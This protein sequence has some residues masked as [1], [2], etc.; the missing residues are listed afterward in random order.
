MLPS[1]LFPGFSVNAGSLAFASRSAVV[2]NG[3]Y[4]AR[5]ANAAYALLDAFPLRIDPQTV[6]FS[7]QDGA[8]PAW[9]SAV[10]DGVSC[11]WICGTNN[12]DQAVAQA[13]SY[14]LASHSAPQGEVPNATWFS[15][16]R[17]TRA[18]LQSPV[19]LRGSLLVCGHSYGGAIALAMALWLRQGISQR[20]IHVVTYGSP[21]PG[22]AAAC[23]WLDR[24]IR[25][26]RWVNFNDLVTL[27]PPS[28]SEAPA[29]SRLLGLVVGTQYNIWQQTNSG[30]RLRPGGQGEVGGPLVAVN[31]IVEADLFEWANSAKGA[32][33][34]EHLPLTYAARIGQYSSLRFPPSR[35]QA[36]APATNDGF[37]GTHVILSN[38]A[39]PI[40]QEEEMPTVALNAEGFV[41]RLGPGLYKVAWMGR[42]IASFET[43]ASAKGYVRQMKRLL[44]RTVTSD[45]VYPP[46]FVQSLTDFLNAAAAGGA[47]WDAP[48]IVQV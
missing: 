25:H 21:K 40:S 29:G 32:L 17:I 33:N 3:L 37:E 11:L 46:A 24:N 4:S 39:P 38:D 26:V 13:L 41:R 31:K 10:L 12:Q 9:M 42:I 1:Q 44:V 48:M 16:A 28:S 36:S 34:S 19:G 27:T 35:P 45:G 47:G 43:H 5:N 30:I 2:L 18:A 15:A 7:R 6:L 22:D 14:A 23:A 8:D 20:S